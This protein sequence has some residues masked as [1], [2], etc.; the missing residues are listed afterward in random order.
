VVELICDVLNPS[1]FV[2]DGATAVASEHGG[3][4]SNEHACLMYSF[5]CFFKAYHC[6]VK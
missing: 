2:C 1:S 3:G 5:F 6:W 4:G